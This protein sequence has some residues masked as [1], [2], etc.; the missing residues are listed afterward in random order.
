MDAKVQVHQMGLSTE[1]ERKH[2]EVKGRN[3]GHSSV[4]IRLCVESGGKTRDM[5]AQQLGLTWRINS[6]TFLIH[7][8]IYKRS[9][10]LLTPMLILDYFFTYFFMFH[11]FQYICVP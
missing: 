11:C 10:K 8:L 7:G 2:N 5:D 9:W 3:V 1:E 6:K 4:H